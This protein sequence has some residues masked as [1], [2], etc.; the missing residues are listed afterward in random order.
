MGDS[1]DVIEGKNSLFVLVQTRDGRGEEELIDAAAQANVRVYSTNRY[2]N[3]SAPSE[4][5]YVQ[6]GFAGIPE[7]EIEAGISALADAWG[8]RKN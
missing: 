1:V 6:V 7:K 8:L 2:W 4:W 5:R 3:G